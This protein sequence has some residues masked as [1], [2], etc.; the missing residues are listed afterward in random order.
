METETARLVG[1]GGV[2]P[3]HTAYFSQG[4]ECGHL[5]GLCVPDNYV[6][7]QHLFCPGA[8]GPCL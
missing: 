3:E 1:F 4:A 6:H 8:H 2:G 7:E 5:G